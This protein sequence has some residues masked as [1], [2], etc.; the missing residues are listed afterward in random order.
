MYKYVVN[1]INYLVSGHNQKKKEQIYF[2]TF[3]I[4]EKVESKNSL[5]II[6]LIIMLADE[7]M[8]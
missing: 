8:E 6:V 1:Q 4:L 3:S 7:R 2:S 5:S